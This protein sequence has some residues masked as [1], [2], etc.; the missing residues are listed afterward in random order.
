MKPG[1]GID[2]D[3]NVAE[4]QV[5]GVLEY[6]HIAASARPRSLHRACYRGARYTRLVG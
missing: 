2:L 5:I 3:M 1:G 6:V 4:T